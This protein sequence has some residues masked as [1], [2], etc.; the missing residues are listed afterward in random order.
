MQYQNSNILFSPSDLTA[1][2]DSP[3]ASAM[4]RLKLESP[5]LK[6]FM[7]AEDEMLK[8]LQLKGDEHEKAVDQS[9]R[10]DGL[11]VL[12]L[13]RS[14]NHEWMA[15]ETIRAMEDGQEVIVQGYL[16]DGCFAGFS[17]YLVKVSGDSNFGNYHY[18]VW[19]SKLASSVKPYFIV[20]ICCYIDML[21][22]IQGVRPKEMAVK[23]GNG[24]TVR[25][26]VA[27]Y[28]AYYQSL[29]RNF[30]E[31][32]ENFDGER[33]DPA[34]SKAYGRWS[35]LA[36]RE[37]IEKD[38]LSQV[39]RLSRQQ[40]KN[41]EK[42]GIVTM[43]LLAE[44]DIER[45]PNMGD[46]TFQKAI[47]QA[48]LQI[49][50]FGKERPAYEVLPHGA[51]E[52]KGLAM[53]PAHSDLDVFFDIEG[54]PNMDGG[55]EYLWGNT[56][57]AEDGSRTFIDF[58]AHD[59]DQEKQ[60]FED[61][62]DWIYARWL[63]DPSMHVYHYA[64]YEIAAIRKLM[65]RFGTREEQVDN[66][67]RNNVFVDLYK[68]VSGGLMIGTPNYSIKS[69]ELLYR[70]KRNTEVGN[71]GESIIVYENWRENP[72]GET[73]ETSKTLNDIRNYNIDDCDST[74]ELTAW[75]R[76]QQEKY[77]ITYL[78][79]DG[80]GEKDVPEE[81]TAVIQLRNRLLEQAGQL[82]SLDERRA[83]L[84][85]VLAWSLE[86]HRR[87]NKPTWWR[88]FDRMGQSFIDL[89]DDM[90][91]L[92]GLQRTSA[93][94]EKVSN[95]SNA[96]SLYE[97]SFDPNQPFKGTAKSYYILGEDNLKAECKMYDAEEGLIVLKTGKN[98]PDSI[99]IVPDEYVRP[100]PIPASI[101]TVIEG[102]LNTDFASS[103]IVDFLTRSRPRIK[104]NIEGPIVKYQGDL[105]TEVIEASVN[106][107]RSYLSIQGPPGAGKTYTA[108]HI[109][110][111]L[112]RQGKKIGIS[113]NSHKAILNLMHGAAE[114]CLDQGIA[115]DFVKVGGDKSEPIFSK[116]NVTHVGGVKGNYLGQCTG[117]TAWGF[118]NDEVAGAFDYL[119]V[120]EAGQ[121]SVANLIGMSRATSNII[122]LGDQMQLG[123]PIQGSHP[124]DSGLSVLDY[125]LQDHATIPDNL[126]VFLPVTY[127]CH[128]DVTGLI[129]E[130]V[131][132]GRLRAAESTSRHKIEAKGP[133]IT[134]SSGV[135]F[136]PVMHEGNTQGSDEEVAVIKDIVSELL[137]T[138]Y[139]PEIEGG[140]L[141]V[142]A[143]NDI[144]FVAPY[145]FQVN[146]LRV[147]LGPE[148]KIGSVDKFQGQEAPVVIMSMCASDATESPRGLDFLFNKNRLNV[149]LSRAQALAIVVGSPALAN[150]PVSKPEQMELINFYCAIVEGE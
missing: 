147:A 125:L 43:R 10:D 62:V 59:R 117:A 39:A 121:V 124:G 63:A 141:R 88:L 4:E 17:D 96:T 13:K 142:L 50:S 112:L 89:Y 24:E 36:S 87:E 20:Q 12:E 2:M 3:Y 65:G 128:P 138:H 64:N 146:K 129:S 19:D 61:F 94:I 47:H 98:L 127:R 135:Q 56:Y 21:E 7:D 58:W 133:L 32:H 99:D 57:Y 126:G 42:S 137:G 11:D 109:I 149:A 72:D 77:E 100:D 150:T 8:R 73:W 15:A 145:N 136:V 76:K 66:L 148:A 119:F 81:V 111:E 31:F 120:D 37:L 134:R 86:F 115:A 5:E 84:M 79:P 103:A 93:Q 74:Q 45:I 52:V 108:K 18:E 23:L 69:V 97:Y 116:E 1:Y 80:E 26:P 68:V 49:A 34:V 16:K 92:V 40:I 130:Q 35:E 71:G 91:C 104:G 54:Y 143:L 55:L 44:T 14:N 144:L 123:Q 106:L 101:Q 140:E 102:L 85:E 25:L 67:L 105:L 22:K 70:G 29:K 139:W 114:Y 30:L 118:C 41:L 82:Q 78:L 48:Q 53:L 9:M 107:D 83:Q 95:R 46:A 33:P 122:L 113:S 51:G 60:A 131:Y 38:H 90:D 6:K 110:G 132:E 28:Y 27:R 75:L